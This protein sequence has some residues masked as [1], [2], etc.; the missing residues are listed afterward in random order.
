[1]MDAPRTRHHRAFS[2]GRIAA[3]VLRHW[4]LL[5]SSWPRIFELLYWPLLQLLTWGFLQRYLNQQDGLVGAASRVL[6]G[7]VLLWEV[8][9][10]GQLGV[11]LSFLEEVWSR[12][13]AN[14]LLSPLTRVELLASLLIISLIRVALT[15]VPISLLALFFFDFNLWSLGFALAG[16]FANLLLTGWSVAILTSGI[17][18][19]HGLGAESLVWTMLFVLMPLSCVF[20]PVASLPP[21]LQQVAWLLPPTHVFEGMRALIQQQSFSAALMLRA[22]AINIVFI[23][24]AC[25]G[26]L[27]LLNGAR[28]N[29][30]LMSIGE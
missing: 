16:Y 7:G 25:F 22:S 15:I 27:K 10:R 13:M 26:F 4:Y 12:N 1:M 20:Y 23:S 29:G 21:F 6:L 17:V 24:A 19:K 5:R 11:S 14:L 28:R 18:L 9:V 2:P 30:S 8:L 3:I